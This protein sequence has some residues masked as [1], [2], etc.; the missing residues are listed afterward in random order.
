MVDFIIL[1]LPNVLPNYMIPVAYLPVPSM[2]FTNSYKLDRKTLKENASLLSDSELKLA[3]TTQMGETKTGKLT[4]RKNL[5][6][7]YMCLDTAHCS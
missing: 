1:Q 7:K 3:T 5:L 4:E 6:A 2:P